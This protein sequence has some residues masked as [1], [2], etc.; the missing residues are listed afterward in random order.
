M[1]VQR[2]L[3]RTGRPGWMGGSSLAVALLAWAGC[4]GASMRADAAGV[5]AC[6]GPTGCGQPCE[7][8][9]SVGVGRYCTAGGRECLRFA[10]QHAPFCTVDFDPMARPYC[11]GPCASNGQCGESATCRFS[12]DGGTGGCVPTSCSG[13]GA[14]DAASPSDAGPTAG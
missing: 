14:Q 3:G 8:G 5:D 12:P 13:G 4:G 2:T 9:N 6:V 1:K 7:L 10:T 11:T